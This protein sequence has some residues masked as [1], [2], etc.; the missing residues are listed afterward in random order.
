MMIGTETRTY[1]AIQVIVD[2]S[3][4]FADGV[5]VVVQRVIKDVSL[6]QTHVHNGAVRLYD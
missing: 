2:V 3:V 4:R 6:N 1:L 5:R